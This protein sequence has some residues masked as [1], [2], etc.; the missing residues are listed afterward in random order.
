M[1]KF[2]IE[3]I[4]NFKFA[5][6][7]ISVLFCIWLG[8]IIKTENSFLNPSGNRN[9]ANQKLMVV[10]QDSGEI[11]FIQKSLQGI[12]NQIVADDAE[13]SNAL[14]NLLGDNMGNYGG[15]TKSGNN[16]VIS[17]LLMGGA[18][19]TNAQH[20][21]WYYQQINDLHSK[22]G[23]VEKDIRDFKKGNSMAA[24]RGAIDN[25]LRRGAAYEIQVTDN[26]GANRVLDT[27]DGGLKAAGAG[28][29]CVK[30]GNSDNHRKFCLR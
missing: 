14:R 1:A 27:W 16:G 13:I 24:V 20:T 9:P 19:K 15:Y 25:S 18:D 30:T 21:A 11:S 12:N 23:A 4:M 29:G 7:V 6:F 2:R 3:N 17:K 28:Q 10:D 5:L 26:R 8:L 22:V